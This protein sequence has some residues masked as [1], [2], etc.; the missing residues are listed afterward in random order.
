MAPGGMEC[1]GAVRGAR[2]GRDGGDVSSA[3]TGHT[4]YGKVAVLTGSA[5]ADPGRLLG[6]PVVSADGTAIAV[7]LQTGSMTRLFI[8]RLD[9]DRLVQLDG[10][11][12]AAYPAWSPDSRSVRFFAGDKLK[13]VSAAGGAPVVLCSAP[14]VIN[15]HGGAWSRDG[16]IIFGIN[17]RGI[18]R[19]PKD[20]GEPIE[21][22][23]LDKSP[24]GPPFLLTMSLRK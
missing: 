18:F 4:D 20:G 21:L 17:F 11:D 22:T 12:G 6:P 2:R 8:R 9:S 15:E 5:L 14:S 16:T 3:S 13:V 24:A 19:C 7:A 23:T 10:I 1:R